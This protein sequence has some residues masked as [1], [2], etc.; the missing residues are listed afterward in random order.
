MSDLISAEL[1]LSQLSFVQHSGTVR[2][3]SVKSPPHPQL[4]GSDKCSANSKNEYYNAT[5]TKIPWGILA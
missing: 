5:T 3:M 1:K 4:G 2:S